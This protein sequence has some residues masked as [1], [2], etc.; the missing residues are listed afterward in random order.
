MACVSKRNRLGAFRDEITAEN[1]R[2]LL[3]VC[4]EAV[5]TEFVG[6]LLVPRQEFRCGNG[7]RFNPGK[8]PFGKPRIAVVEAYGRDCRVQP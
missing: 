7:R 6:Q 5:Q 2:K 8:E 3:V 4:T 1:L